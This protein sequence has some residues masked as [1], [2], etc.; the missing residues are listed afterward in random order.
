MSSIDAKGRRYPA[1][2]AADHDAL[3]SDQALRYVMRELLTLSCVAQELGF[4]R[5]AA[6]LHDTLSV[7]IMETA[8]MPEAETSPDDAEVPQAAKG[9]K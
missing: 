7:L 2:C 3:P 5:T 9:R 6:S 8:A 4:E 1:G